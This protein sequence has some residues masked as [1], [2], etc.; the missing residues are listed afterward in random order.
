MKKV[1]AMDEVKIPS[2][3]FDGK[4]CPHILKL[5]R[6]L[7]DKNYG[8]VFAGS[9]I[10][11]QNSGQDRGTAFE[12]GRS[13]LFRVTSHWTFLVTCRQVYE[14]GRP[15][16]WSKTIV[17]AHNDTFIAL[18]ESFSLFA[19]AHVR[20]LRSIVWETIPGAESCYVLSQFPH[21]ETVE[22]VLEP[23]H[24]LAKDY[25][26]VTRK[27]ASILAAAV[28]MLKC[29]PY[30]CLGR[31]VKFLAHW[32]LSRICLDRPVDGYCHMVSSCPRYD[33]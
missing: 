4:R 28:Q 8:L 26:D 19:K 16:Y 10:Y 21:V 5:P 3:E 27:E 11:V 32:S 22:L 15:V 31:P 24:L 6:G 1:A 9:Y 18:S 7:L 20:H 30:D 29:Q 14:Q 25:D 13:S 33:S 23:Q 2:T 12:I 17:S